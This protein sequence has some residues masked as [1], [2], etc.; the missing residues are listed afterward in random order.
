MDMDVNWACDGFGTN[1]RLDL[2]VVEKELQQV[3][4]GISVVGHSQCTLF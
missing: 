2:D 3:I 4:D 1:V